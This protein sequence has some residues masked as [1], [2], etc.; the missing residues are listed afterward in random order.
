MPNKAVS[1]AQYKFFR[2]VQ[3]GDVKSPGL[4]PEKASEMLG[5]QSPKG[6]PAHVPKKPKM[7]GKWLTK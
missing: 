4:S 1:Q 3:G 2:A 6:L 7:K 5:H